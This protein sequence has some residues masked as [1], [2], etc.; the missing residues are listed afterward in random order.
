M[1]ID[2]KDSP[3]IYLGV[4]IPDWIEQDITPN[5]IDAICQGGCASGAYMPAVTYYDAAQMMA[6]HGDS[7]LDYIDE[8]MG[9]LPPIPE[10]T[11]WSGIAVLYL[12]FAVELWAGGAQVACDRAIEAAEAD[13][14]LAHW[15][16]PD[17]IADCESDAIG[18]DELRAERDA[19]VRL[20]NFHVRHDDGTSLRLG[21]ITHLVNLPGIG[22]SELGAIVR[23]FNGEPWPAPVL[24]RDLDFLARR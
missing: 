1:D 21:Q 20:Q 4:D 23:H 13:H 6:K 9:E 14:P 5:D 3:A 12:S 8:Q 16:D 22:G 19:Y 11:S 24:V 15:L 18:S 2:Y 10:G 17:S 7:V